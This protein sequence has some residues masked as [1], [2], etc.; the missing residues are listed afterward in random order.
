VLGEVYYVL[1]ADDYALPSK[2]AF[3]PE[4]SFLGRIRVDSVPPPHTPT[5][6]KRCIL[7]VEKN[8][9]LAYRNTNLFVDT[10]CETPLDDG[11]ISLRT[12]GPGLSPDEP[13]AIVL[14]PPIP[15]PD[16][17]YL[18]KNRAADIYWSAEQNPKK[19]VYFY[20]TTSEHA[21]MRS[22]FQVN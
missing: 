14:N 1:Y 10:S 18:I 4:E 5:S 15:G 22:F 13:M 21:K 6:I 17:R 2:V 11:H 9:K 3:D 16:G 12:D 8:P 19:T 20:S 7:R